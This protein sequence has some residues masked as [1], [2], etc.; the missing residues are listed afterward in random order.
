M[1][2]P[3]VCFSSKPRAVVPGSAP[4]NFCLQA[5]LTP[6]TDNAQAIISPNIRPLSRRVGV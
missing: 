4:A 2:K 5:S 1:N 6:S 3:P